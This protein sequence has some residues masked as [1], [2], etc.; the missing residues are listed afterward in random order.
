MDKILIAI[1]GSESAR[2]A[3]RFGVKLAAEQDAEA[4]FVLVVPALDVLPAG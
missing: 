1:D 3:T 2:K 4:T